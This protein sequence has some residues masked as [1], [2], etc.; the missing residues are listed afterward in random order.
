MRA[1]LSRRLHCCAINMGSAT[2][3][4]HGCRGHPLQRDNSHQQPSQD[5]AEPDHGKEFSQ[6]L[7]HGTG[8]QITNLL[9]RRRRS[10]ELQNA[11]DE[12]CTLGGVQGLAAAALLD[13]GTGK[14]GQVAILRR[15]RTSVDV[16][17]A[18]GAPFSVREWCRAHEAGLLGAEAVTMNALATLH[19]VN[20]LMRNVAD[21][22][23]YRAATIGGHRVTAEGAELLLHLGAGTVALNG[24]GCETG[25]ASDP[26]RAAGGEYEG[27]REGCKGESNCGFTDGHAETPTIV[28]NEGRAGGARRDANDCTTGLNVGNQS[29]LGADPGITVVSGQGRLLRGS[30]GLVPEACP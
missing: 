22:T 23:S 2:A 16:L 13:A 3:I 30:D 15:W 12:K 14:D 24:V 28:E 4:Q 21:L 5:D 9:S 6:R 8:G 11:P 27:G 10:N 29:R 19:G 20:V 26:A 1:L 25:L 18:H 7:V 17:L